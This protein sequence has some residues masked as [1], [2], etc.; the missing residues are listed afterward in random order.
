MKTWF[1]NRTAYCLLNEP[2]PQCFIELDEHFDT[3]FATTG[4]LMHLSVTLAENLCRRIADVELVAWY[5]SDAYK[6]RNT[7]KAAIHIGSLIVW[8]FSTCKSLMDAGAI[9]LATIYNLTLTQKEMDFSKAKFWNQLK[10]KHPTV[11]ARYISFKDLLDEIVRWRDT[12][13]HRLTPLV[14]THSPGHPDTVPQEK[15]EI[16]MVARPDIT[17]S[18][19]ATAPK[20]IQWAE[21]L[22]FHGQWKNSLIEFCK[23]VCSD[24]RNYT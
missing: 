14:L 23:E 13:V 1:Y 7:F 12:A 22:H 15:R 18:T 2:V 10:Q 19:V 4:A 21:P 6:S 24:I 17:I 3:R 5:I 8:Y 20:S 9:T 16:K 11:H